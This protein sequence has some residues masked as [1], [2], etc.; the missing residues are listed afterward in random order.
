MAL[1]LADEATRKFGGDSVA[2]VRAQRRARSR[3][4]SAT[5]PLW[6]RR[7]S[8]GTSRWSGSWGRARPP[9]AAS[10]RP[11]S[12]RPFIDADEALVVTTGRTVRQ[13]FDELGRG[14][15]PRQAEVDVLAQLL[16]QRRS[17]GHRHGRR[18]RGRTEAGRAL[19]A[20]PD[21]TVVWLRASPAFVAN[22]VAQKA[23]KDHRP[24]LD[25]DPRRRARAPLRRARP[26]LRRGR[27]RWSSTSTRC[28]ATS[29][30][31]RRSWPRWCSRRSRRST[32][33]RPPATAPSS[34]ARPRHPPPHRAGRSRD[35]APGR[36]RRPQLPG[37]RR[38]RC[39]PPPARRA[40]RSGV[41]RAAIVTQEA[42]GG[43]RRPGRRAPH[44]HHPRRRGPQAPRHRRGPLPRLGPLGPHPWRRA[45]WPWAVGSSPTWPASPRRS[46]TGASPWCTWPPP[47]WPRST[48]P[49]AARP[50]VNLPEGKNLVG[51]FW[52]PCRRPVRHRDAGHAAAPRVPQRASARWPSTRSSASTGLR[53]LSLDEAVAACVRCKAEVVASDER[54]GGPPG[55]PQLRPHPRPRPRDGRATTTCATARPSPSGWSTRPRWRCRLGRIDAARVAEHRRIVAA[56]DLPMT[57]PRRHRPGRAGRAVRPRQEGRRR[58]HLRARRPRRRRAG[59]RRRPCAAPRRPGGRPMTATPHRA[60]ALRPEPEPARRAAAAHLRLRHARRPRRARPRHGRRARARPRAR[61]VQPRGR[62]GRRRCTARGAGAPPSS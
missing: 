37:A 11:A 24:L 17:V 19:L 32:P 38:P 50:G 44:L 46:S 6:L 5:G 14:R 41:R 42:V 25:A 53:D 13:W 2:R 36:A 15:V 51:A 62:P 9:S 12:S 8:G 22:R 26:P 40:A 52:Q 16:D 29:R 1:V 33:R 31:P 48:P 3:P 27:R 61:A 57:L 4:R 49:S 43:H 20:V 54:E 18:H 7:S 34:P 59:P 60:A 23:N 21:V 56:Y 39:P 47:C 30:S 28:T 10:W 58:P 55:H 45:S 35:R